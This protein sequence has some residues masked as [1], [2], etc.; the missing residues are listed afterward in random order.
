MNAIIKA[1]DEVMYRIPRY[2]LTEVFQQK[3]YKWRDTPLS[4]EEQITNQV[5]K[6]RVLVD[7]NIVGGTEVFIPLEGIQ[8]DMPNSY[9]AVYHIPKTLTQGRTI[10]SVLSVGFVTRSSANAANNA[11]NVKQCSITPELMAAQNVMDS[12]SPIPIVSGSQVR[13]IGENTI[14]LRGVSPI[15]SNGFL[16]CVL[17]SDDELSHIQIRSYHHFCKLVE[18]AVKSFIYNETIIN[19][20]LA[21][22][23]GGREL[24]MF[25]TV[26][27][28]YSDAEQMYQDYL[29]DVWVGVDYMNDELTF[30]RF[31]K[32][33][34]GGIR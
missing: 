32:T 5:I 11:M 26:V 14:L 33:L 16:R 22:L 9:T 21:K 24:G 4:I 1:V 10:T 2:V 17:A 7:C 8:P 31:I 27:E 28:S 20:D 3:T 13:L 29:K 19:I 30:N 6:P 18:L 34:V 23:S 12:Y 25:K 15:V